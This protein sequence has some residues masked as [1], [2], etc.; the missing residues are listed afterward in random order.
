MAVSSGL[1]D[2]IA[3]FVEVINCG[4]FTNAAEQTG[5]STSY[6][7]KEVGK[8][9]AR[10]GVRLL[11]RTTRTLKLTPEGELY[12]QQCRQIIDD[13]LEAEN[14]VSGKQGRPKG[15]LRVSCPVAFGVSKLQP[16]LAQYTS[17]YP[18][19]SLE[20]DLNDRKVDLIADGFDVVIRAT[21]QMEDS[22]LVSRLVM[23]SPALTL[24]SPEYLAKHGV[25]QHPADLEKHKAICYSNL[26]NPTIWDYHDKEGATVSVHVDGQVLTNNSDMI[27]ALARAGEG[28]IRIPAFNLN[29]ELQTGQLVPVLQD[30]PQLTIGIYMVY[31]SRKHMSAKV[32]SF[33]DFIV[34]QFGE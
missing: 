3:I 11:H 4:S 13:A 10:L 22:S 21:H 14:A 6:I 24:A 2:G 12:Y 32:R 17:A 8:L 27:M 5:H 30:Y 26:K 20:L 28:V 15:V 16:C 25:P 34:E 9:E 29:D 18:D 19:I 31:P 33:I 1:F 23:R 7:S